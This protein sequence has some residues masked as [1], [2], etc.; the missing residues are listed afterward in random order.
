MIEFT[1]D[2]SLYEAIMGSVIY[3]G[4]GCG[5]GAFLANVFR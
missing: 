3:F 1:N 5:I 4:S 2:P